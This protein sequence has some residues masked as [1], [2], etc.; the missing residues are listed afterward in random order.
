[1][2]SATWLLLSSNA[3]YRRNWVRPVLLILLRPVP[4][5]VAEYQ[6]LTG[7]VLK[8]P[9]FWAEAVALKSASSRAAALNDPWR[10]STHSLP[11]I[12]KGLLPTGMPF[13]LILSTTDWM[14]AVFGR[15]AV[16]KDRIALYWRLEVSSPRRMVLAVI[17]RGPPTLLVSPDSSTQPS[18]L[19][20]ELNVFTT[21]LST[22][23]VT[24]MIVSP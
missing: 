20:R 6:P 12:S 4:F 15:G 1:M 18:W 24:G 3:K 19:A 9:T 14:T 23:R 7:V 17:F 2:K 8:A 5:K 13:F 22:S 11:R 16:L 21:A 10:M